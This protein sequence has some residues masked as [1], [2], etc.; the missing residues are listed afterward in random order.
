MAA[1]EE[2]N[3]LPRLTKAF[4]ALDSSTHAIDTAAFAAAMEKVRWAVLLPVC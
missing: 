4:V 3:W 1:Q 2:E